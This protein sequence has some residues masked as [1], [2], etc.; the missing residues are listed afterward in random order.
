MPGSLVSDPLP[1]YASQLP[2]PVRLGGQVVLRRWSDL[3]R[4]VHG[5][6]DTFPTSEVDPAVPNIW[7]F[8]YFANTDR[9]S[10]QFIQG[11]TKI[12]FYDDHLR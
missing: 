2:I 8:Q 7:I 5:N 6:G 10:E 4:P 11:E 9:R 3:R 1:T 12:A